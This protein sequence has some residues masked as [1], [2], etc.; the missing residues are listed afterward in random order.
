MV[1]TLAD[2]MNH[3][4][5][6]LRASDLA[7]MDAT[8]TEL[9]PLKNGNDLELFLV[10]D[11]TANYDFGSKL[12]ELRHFVAEQPK[13][14]AIGVAYIHEGTLHV[15]ENPTTDHA[16]VAQAL[17][18]PSG[19]KASSP[20][21]ALSSLMERW[22]H[23][24]TRREIVLVS[25]GMDDAAG[26]GV[27][28]VNAETAIHD[29]E[30]AGIVIFALYNPV[31]GYREEKWSKVDSGVVD[32]AHVCFETGGEAYF[33]SHNP[34][35]SIVPFLADIEEHLANQY[36]LKFRRPPPDVSSLQPVYLVPQSADLEL[37][38]FEYVWV[39]AAPNH[40]ER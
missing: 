28:C 22:P 4:P 17:R 15:E 34:V 38:F 10:I 11:D 19:G 30:R 1:V 9:L 40:T 33:L 27:I 36:L 31:A 14:E 13:S 23:K 8:I 35:D 3:K 2:H 37:M 12:R 32:L 26:E 5:Q 20:Y 21:C 6:A 29:A 18:A 16:R 7:I 25:T 39:P 24:T